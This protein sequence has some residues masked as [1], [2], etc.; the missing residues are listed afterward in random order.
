M[1]K[2]I[3]EFKA[4]ILF[5]SK[6]EVKAS[7][8]DAKAAKKAFTTGALRASSIV[9]RELPSALTRA[10]ESSVWGPFNPKYPYN[11]KNGELVGSGMRDM[12]DM[13]GLHDSLKIKTKFLAT[14]TQTIVSYSA[15]YARLTHEGG[16]I[17][18]YGNATAAAVVLPARP[19]IKSVLTGDGPVPQYNYSQVYQNEITDAWNGA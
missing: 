5:P 2:K 17:Q 13:G 9:E 1:A 10:L 18:P 16:V 7:G 12:I 19:W 4:D 14:K 8:T 6:A 15:P 11:R 3:F